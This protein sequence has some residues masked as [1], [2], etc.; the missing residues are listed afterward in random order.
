MDVKDLE[1]IASREMLKHGLLGWTFGLAKTKRR[2]G[3][4]NDRTKRIEIAEYYARNSPPGTV[5]DTLLH[6]IANAI[7]GPAAG[8]DP[9][10]KAVALRL[11]ATPRACDHSHETAVTPGDPWSL[12]TT[13][14][15]PCGYDVHLS[16]ADR[17]IVN[18]SWGAHNFS[19]ADTGF[20][21]LAKL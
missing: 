17:S 7:A 2:L 5:L 1:A 11:G 21:L 3:V 10:W 18:S 4:C 15:T 19:S 12:N 9:A 16:V 8:H 14:M 20:C 6:E 13:G